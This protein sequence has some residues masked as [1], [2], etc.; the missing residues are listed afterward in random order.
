MKKIIMISIAVAAALVLSFCFT[1]CSKYVSSY[2]AIGVVTTNSSDSS[3]I[4]FVSLDGTRVL[5]L[6]CKDASTEKLKYSAKLKEG[7]AVVYYDAGDGKKE[8]FTIRAGEEVSSEI[9]GLKKGKVYIIIETKE[10]CG[11]GDFRFDIV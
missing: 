3:S 11:E 4:G 1:G 5:T 8:L 6:K 2:N 9:D 10:K 7:S